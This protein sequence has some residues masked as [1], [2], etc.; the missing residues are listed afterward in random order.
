M[1]LSEMAGRMDPTEAA[2][3][4]GQPAKTLAEALGRETNA[5]ARSSLASAVVGGGGPGWTRP[6]AARICGQPAK[7]LAEA[8]GR[9]TDFV[10][11]QLLLAPA[12]RV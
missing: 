7:T 10:A 9:E 5:R 3:I 11:S 6:R 12:C 2:R 4:C 8:L 1:A